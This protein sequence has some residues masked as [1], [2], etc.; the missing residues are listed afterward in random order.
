MLMLHTCTFLPSF[1]PLTNCEEK[2]KSKQRPNCAWETCVVTDFVWP[3]F[4][5]QFEYGVA[6]LITCLIQ[7]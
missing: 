7:S 6:K 3:L 1:L 4:A 5:A 2:E